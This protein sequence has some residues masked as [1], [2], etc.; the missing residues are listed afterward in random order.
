[1]AQ[2]LLYSPMEKNAGNYGQSQGYNPV[3]ID[4]SGL[5][6]RILSH[7]M[8]DKEYIMKSLMEI[9]TTNQTLAGLESRDTAK[10]FIYAF[11]YGAGNKNPG[12]ICGRSQSM[13][14]IKKDF[15]SL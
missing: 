3:G 6:L 7:Y 9:Y 4:A 11:I 2:I 10:T 1:M 5:E 8:N 12:S 15:L 13:E 14:K